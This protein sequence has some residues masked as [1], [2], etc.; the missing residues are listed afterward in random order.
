[1]CGSM[2]DIQCATAEI[3]RGI[4]KTER[5]NHRTKNIMS[6]SAAQ[7]GHKYSMMSATTF[8]RRPYEWDN[9][10]CRRLLTALARAGDHFIHILWVFF[11]VVIFLI[12]RAFFDVSR[13]RFSK[14]FHMM[15]LLS[16]PK[17]CYADFLNAFWSSRVSYGNCEIPRIAQRECVVKNGR[18]KT[19]ARLRLVEKRCRSEGFTYFLST[20]CWCRVQNVNK[21]SRW[22]MN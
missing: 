14:Y 18:Q 15:W 13:V 3:R 5:R 16:I 8:G 21:L 4:K 2:V 12:Q 1:M 6:A 7:G 19:R 22:I 10:N 9:S 20:D 11:S 17:C